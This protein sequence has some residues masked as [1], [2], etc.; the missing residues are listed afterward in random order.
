MLQHARV[1][2]QEPLRF[3]TETAAE[4]GDVV[5]FPIPGRRVFY[6]DADG[7]YWASPSEVT[8]GAD[9]TMQEATHGDFVAWRR[10]AV[11][12]LHSDLRRTI[13]TAEVRNFFYA[14]SS[15]P[16]AG[17]VETLESIDWETS[18]VFLYGPLGRK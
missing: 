8:T 17:M 10:D 13:A 4:L 5:E 12:L 16:R 9:V 15:D 2:R 3:L 14:T 7:K 6:V 1:M 18:R 11:A